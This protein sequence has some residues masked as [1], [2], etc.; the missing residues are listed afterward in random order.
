MIK[1]VVVPADPLAPLRVADLDDHDLDAQ[2]ALVGGLI[3]HVFLTH[4]DATL[5]M[6][7]TGKIDDLSLNER[8]TLLFWL[9]APAF[10]G[11]DVIVGDAYLTGPCDGEHD[12]DIPADLLAILTGPT[13]AQAQA[14]AGD[15]PTWTTVSNS[16]ATTYGPPFDAYATA[17]LGAD[18]PHILDVRVVPG[19]SALTDAGHEQP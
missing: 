1:I 18:S 12:T 15:P 16:L 10:R 3:E 9:H 5:Y 7:E 17:L 8:A 11:Y 19:P 13:P 4:P 2:Q 6:R 14:L